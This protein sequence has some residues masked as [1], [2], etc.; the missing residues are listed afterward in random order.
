[1]PE[2]PAKLD[3]VMTLLQ[4]APGWAE[5]RQAIIL[6]QNAAQERLL[7]APQLELNL[8]QT[9]AAIAEVNA[10][11]R[12]LGIP[13]E[14]SNAAVKLREAE[15]KGKSPARPGAARP[16]ATARARSATA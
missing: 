11:A 8:E 9:Y 7:R 4:D 12:V 3:F 16:S 1:M 10:F 14:L 15:S 13:M 5:Y 2:D 6:K